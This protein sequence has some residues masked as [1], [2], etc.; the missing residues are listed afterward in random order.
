MATTIGQISAVNPATE[1]VI[2]SFDAF[3]PDEVASH[4]DS[5][6]PFGVSD[7]AGNSWDLVAG[8][9]GKPWMKGGAWYYGALTADASNQNGGEATQRNIRLGIKL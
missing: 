9:D 5:D 6:S 8:V 4:P 7:M 2:A 1:E 3:G